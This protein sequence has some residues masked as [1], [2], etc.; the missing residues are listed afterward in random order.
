VR[1]RRCVFAAM[2]TAA[3]ASC[4]TSRDTSSKPE[5]SGPSA[6]TVRGGAALTGAANRSTSASASHGCHPVIRYGGSSVGQGNV[7]VG[8][9][10]AVPPG[11]RCVLRGVPRV[12]LVDRHGRPLVT[13][14][15]RDVSRGRRTRAVDVRSGH[16]SS[17]QV[18]YRLVDVETN[19]PC[20]VAA[21]IVVRFHGVRRPTTFLMPPAVEHDAAHEKVHVFA[22]CDGR[23]AV[24]A[25]G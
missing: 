3:L 6:A 9:D 13:R 20:R 10:V 8:F 24:T 7:F 15:V 11:G 22:P 17:F 16:P 12:R 5:V 4:G 1:G 2:A 18:T 23:I 14:E 21:G 19:T 25:M